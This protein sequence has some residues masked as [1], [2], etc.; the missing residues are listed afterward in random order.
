MAVT[1]RL[2]LP[3]LAAGQAQKEIVHNEALAL[4]EMLIQ[5]CAQSLGENDPPAAP[6][7]GRNWIVGDV[8]TGV[9]IGHAHAIAG[10]SEGGWRFVEPVEG[11][12]FFIAGDG[13]WARFRDG[14]WEAGM[15]DGAVVRID[16]IQVVG[17]QEAPISAPSGGVTID[18][19]ARA[20]IAALLVAMRTHGLIST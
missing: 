18:S 7:P 3:M 17:A 16:G 2:R 19:E 4:A 12:H 5:P 14:G 13:R 1:P 20:A 8:P 9:W 6:E 11:A 15:I 10:W